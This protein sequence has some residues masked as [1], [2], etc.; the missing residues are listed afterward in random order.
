MS[1]K[2]SLGVLEAF[3]ERCA[4]NWVYEYALAIT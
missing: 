4:M 1:H 3:G 2:E